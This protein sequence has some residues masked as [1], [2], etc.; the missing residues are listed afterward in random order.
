MKAIF[1]L[2]GLLETS[3]ATAQTAAP[4]NPGE[5]PAESTNAPPASDTKPAALTDATDAKGLRSDLELHPYRLFGGKQCYLIRLLQWEKLDSTR[6]HEEPNPM[7]VW[8][9]FHGT[10]LLVADAGMVFQQSNDFVFVKNHPA[11]KSLTNGQSLTFHAIKYGSHGYTNTEGDELKLDA[12]DYGIPF[13][14]KILPA[15]YRTNLAALYR[16]QYIKSLNDQ[17][18]ALENSDNQLRDLE[19]N[20]KRAESNY[21]QSRLMRIREQREVQQVQAQRSAISQ[22]ITDLKNQKAQIEGT[23]TLSG[24]NANANA[25][26]NTTLNPG[27]PDPN[28]PAGSNPNLN[29]YPNRLRGGAGTGPP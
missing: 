14:P 19:L 24:T 22:Q 8:K 6:R 12:F 20:L 23:A 4:K 29:R 2:I 10:V 16:A 3:A 7:P 9:P 18:S 25:S 26:T 15:N 1:L 21:R 13:Y 27:S 5:P 11:Q 17:I 28:A